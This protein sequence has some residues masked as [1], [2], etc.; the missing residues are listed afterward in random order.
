M[1]C[2]R[3]LRYFFASL[4]DP[5]NAECYGALCDYNPEQLLSHRARTAVDL[6]FI[7]TSSMSIPKVTIIC[8]TSWNYGDKPVGK[9]MAI[10][11]LVSFRVSMLV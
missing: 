4:K 5:K 3:N 11:V 6:F 8:P 2:A 10:H 1:L 7:F 9:V